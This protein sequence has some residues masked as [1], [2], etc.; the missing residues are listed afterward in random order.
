ML[1][2]SAAIER[3]CEGDLEKSSTA[4]EAE[5]L[6]APVVLIVEDEFSVRWPAAE[7]LRE[8]AY[9]VIEASNANDAITC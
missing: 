8:I 7:Y 9:S 6:R 5:V 4:P 3:T 1:F 2:Y